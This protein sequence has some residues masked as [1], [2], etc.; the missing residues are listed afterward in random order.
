MTPD[1]PDIELMRWQDDGGR[2]PGEPE[3]EVWFLTYDQ[4]RGMF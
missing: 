2:C 1:V 4:L 3:E